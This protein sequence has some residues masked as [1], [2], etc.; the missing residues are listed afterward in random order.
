MCT[1][2]ICLKLGGTEREKGVFVLT[3][4]HNERFTKCK[5]DSKMYFQ[6]PPALYVFKRLSMRAPGRR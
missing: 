6:G 5:A 2:Y 4:G 1:Y 3:T